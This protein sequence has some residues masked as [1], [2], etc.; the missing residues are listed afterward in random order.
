MGYMGKVNKKGRGAMEEIEETN[1][2]VN[3][4]QPPFLTGQTTKTG[5]NLSPVRVVKNPEGTLNRSAMNAIQYAKER[6][7]IRQQKNKNE[8]RD[9]NKLLDETVPTKN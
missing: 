6:R 7:Q 8:V 1:I 4:R 3:E 5:I 9:L 2:E